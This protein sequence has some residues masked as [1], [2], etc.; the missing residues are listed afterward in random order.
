MVVDCGSG[1]VVSLK[2]SHEPRSEES[3][4]YPTTEGRIEVQRIG[5]EVL[6]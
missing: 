1:T 6:M 2:S 4:Q 5:V 3:H